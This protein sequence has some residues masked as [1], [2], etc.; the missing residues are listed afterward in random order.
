MKRIFWIAFATIVLLPLGLQA[1]TVDEIIAKNVQ[2]RGG[3]EK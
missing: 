2:A 3:L 1:Q